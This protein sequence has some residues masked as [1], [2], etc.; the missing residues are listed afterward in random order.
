[1]RNLLSLTLLCVMVT[2]SFSSCSEDEREEVEFTFFSLYEE[3]AYLDVGEEMKLEYMCFSEKIIP[4]VTWESSDES[5]AIVDE[6]GLV[7]ALKAGKAIIIVKGTYGGITRESRCELTVDNVKAYSI[8]LSEHRRTL[9]VDETFTLTYT[10]EPENTT[11]KSVEWFVDNNKVVSVED[12]K[13]IALSA[14]E[15]NVFVKIK[16]A[17]TL[18]ICYIT[19]NPVKVEGVALDNSSIEVE[20]NRT[21]ALTATIF[22]ENA[23]DKTLRWRSTDESVATVTREWFR[24][25]KKECVRLS[26]QLWMEILKLNVR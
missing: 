20:L 18:D 11:N 7:K 26:C 14:G 12:G 4:E 21:Y 16:G 9:D 1:M 25:L 3:W 8:E 2:F 15:A 5:V 22:P 17:G 10:I 19:V 6:N 13:V 24:E 23:T